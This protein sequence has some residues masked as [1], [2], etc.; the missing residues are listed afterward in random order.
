MLIETLVLN[1]D[2]GVRHIFRNL[3]IGTVNTVRTGII[4]TFDLIAVLIYDKTRVALR[5]DILCGHFRG[6]LYDLISK[7]SGTGNADDA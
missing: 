6:V 7:Y 3:I 1:S 2:E 5:H 4:E